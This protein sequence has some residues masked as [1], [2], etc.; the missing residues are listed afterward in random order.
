[1]GKVRRFETPHGRVYVY[2]GGEEPIFMPSVTTIL[3]F[4]PSQYLQD[5]EDKIGKEQLQ[6][7]GERAAGRGT[8]MH[9]FLENYMI[10]LKN[11][12]NGDSCL[13]YTQ[14]KT[15]SDLREDL[16]PEDRISYGRDLFYNFVHENTFDDIQ[17]VIFTEKFLWSLEHL[18]AGTADFGYL[19]QNNKRIITDF[20]SASGLRGIDVVNK[21]K[22]QGAAYALSFEEIYKKPIDEVQVWISHPNGLQMEILAGDEMIQKKKEFV[23]LSKDFHSQW[24]VQP[25]VDYYY[26]QKNLQQ[27]Q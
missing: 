17:K 4:E 12:G 1:M 23:E 25:F 2:E 20:K 15:P 10:C 19:N 9:R 21:Y 3:S 26:E 7:I 27:S 24:E 6:V 5:L 16:M 22:K 8:A 14:K 13:L 11:G 18:Y